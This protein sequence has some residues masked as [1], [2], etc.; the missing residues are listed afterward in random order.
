MADGRDLEG[1]TRWDAALP[2]ARAALAEH[3]SLGAAAGAL[4]SAMSSL[5]SA[6]GPLKR[7][8]IDAGRYIAVMAAYYLHEEGELTLAR[9]KAL[10]AGSQL[11]SAGRARAVLRQLEHQGYV[12]SEPEGGERGRR[13]AIA[14]P[15]ASEWLAH[16]RAAL[17]AA[18]PIEPAV[19]LVLSAPDDGPIRTF[20]RLHAEALLATPAH[21]VVEPALIRV[22]M[23]PLAGN[24]I[25]WTLTLLAAEDE[26]PPRVAGPLNLSAL[27]K[28]FGVSRTHLKRIFLAAE[29]EGVARLGRDGMARF[30]EDARAQVA[31]FY[32]SQFQQLLRAAARAA[33]AHGL[34]APA[35][36][37]AP[38]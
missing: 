11:L 25:L 19:D 23:H 38:A 26:F 36:A 9:L 29:R 35:P 5:S 37:T 16:L 20:A 7:I 1:M 28:R 27:A 10:C 6:D 4:A 2:D 14:E 24:Q 3:P 12:T 32:C 13:Y 17:A 34:A 31:G 8:F 18:R 22:F 30:E 21:D 33:R 15:L